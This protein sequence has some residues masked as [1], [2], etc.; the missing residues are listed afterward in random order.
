MLFDVAADAYDRFMGRFSGQLGPLFAD[1]DNDGYK[2]IYSANGYPKA[3]N[4]LDYVNA[5]LAA[6]RRHEEPRGVA[7]GCER[8]DRRVER[9]GIGVVAVVDQ[10]GAAGQAMRHQATG[11][12]TRLRQALGDSATK[13][14]RGTGHEAKSRL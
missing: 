6:R 14:A 5:V 1:F 7:A 10:R 3:V 12:R 9:T 13:P 8:V 4:D 11:D 2:Y